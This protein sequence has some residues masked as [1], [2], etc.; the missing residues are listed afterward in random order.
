MEKHPSGKTRKQNRIKRKRQ[1]ATT[2]KTTQMQQLLLFRRSPSWFQKINLKKVFFSLFTLKRV[3]WN[4]Q[5]ATVERSSAVIACVSSPPGT[6]SVRWTFS[7]R[8]PNLRPSPTCRPSEQRWVDQLWWLVFSL[9]QHLSWEPDSLYSSQRRAVT[10]ETIEVRAHRHTEAV[11]AYV[12]VPLGNAKPTP[13]A[14]GML[15]ALSKL[16]RQGLNLG[17]KAFGKF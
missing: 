1:K 5:L 8:G 14:A 4:G 9:L 13:N 7:L 2:C 15:P 3:K 6:S 17:M 10:Q 16:K 11:A 12:T